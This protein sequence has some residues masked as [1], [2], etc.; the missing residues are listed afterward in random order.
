MGVVNL[1]NGIIA[2]KQYLCKVCRL[3]YFNEV[4]YIDEMYG[5]F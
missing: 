1:L 5:Y 4:L 2:W 3:M